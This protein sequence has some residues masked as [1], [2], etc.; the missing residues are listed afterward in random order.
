ML[1]GS[2]STRGNFKLLI[3]DDKGNLII[4]E[5]SIKTYDKT[6]TETSVFFTRFDTYTLKKTPVSI[7]TNSPVIGASVVTNE[8]SP[9][10]FS[11]AAPSLFSKLDNLQA[12]KSPLIPAGQYLVCICGNNILP[13]KTDVKLLAVPAL[14]EG[15][16]LLKLQNADISLVHLKDSLFQ[17]KTEYIQAKEAFENC[18]SRMNE[19][20]RALYVKLQSRDDAY[21]GFIS[22][23][24]L[25]FA[26]ENYAIPRQIESVAED[27]EAVTGTPLVSDGTVE[28]GQ[29]SKGK[30]KLFVGSK[31]SSSEKKAVS[32]QQV[33]VVLAGTPVEVVTS[34]AAQ[35]G[36][37]IASK[38]TLGIGS[39]QQMVKNATAPPPP[40][41]A[42]P[43]R[44]GESGEGG[45]G[46]KGD[47][48]INVGVS[49]NAASEED[50]AALSNDP[51]LEPIFQELANSKTRF[52]KK[53]KSYKK[54][55]QNHAE[56]VSRRAAQV[57]SDKAR[58]IKEAE[59]STESWLESFGLELDDEQRAKQETQAREFAESMLKQRIGALEH[60]AKEEL[61]A[62]AAEHSS[63]EK[64]S[65][66]EVEY[67]RVSYVEMLKKKDAEV[68]RVQA[69][70]EEEKK[71]KE[72][73]EANALVERLAKEAE[74]ATLHAK[75][76]DEENVRKQEL[77]KEWAE[78]LELER[79][80]IAEAAAIEAEEKRRAVKEAEIKAAKLAEERLVAEEKKNKL[81]KEQKEQEESSQ[82]S[83]SPL[84]ETE[85]PVV[86]PNLDS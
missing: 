30:D 29:S 77:A 27:D 76:E 18:I 13:G 31:S 75:T 58:F 60:K 66:A 68:A 26:P 43:S 53:Q 37:W 33:G 17:L 79:I 80:A 15:P 82:T 16:D 23:S 10:M 40:L 11:T 24:A 54:M 42:F 86:T 71:R 48:S 35:A 1:H 34:T 14:A 25:A 74:N 55:V 4:S 49:E 41:S 52:E 7:E 64:Q 84:E 9:S 47:K 69:I 21:K 67:T 28:T 83:T 6:R 81:L 39:L 5:E 72:E 45:A 62:L 12:V 3:F 44:D 8:L 56:L 85:T 57:E 2:S 59:L 46:G 50:S 70:R 61:N 32:P 20:E 36:G 51:E 65:A 19:Q 22:A 38:V 73:Q 63:K 78:K